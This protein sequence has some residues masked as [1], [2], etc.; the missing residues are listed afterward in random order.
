M[1]ESSGTPTCP[2]C[3]SPSIQA[4]PVRRSSIARALLAE[5]VFDSTAAG[6]AASTRTIILNTCLKCGTQWL[7]G[8]QAEERLRVLSGQRGEQAKREL[9]AGEQQAAAAA[10]KDRNQ[11]AVVLLGLLG[12]IFLAIVAGTIYNNRQAEHYARIAKARADSVEG[13]WLNSA[14]LADSARAA[15]RRPKREPLQGTQ[16]SLERLQGIQDSFDADRA[17]RTLI[18]EGERRR[19]QM[20]RI[21]LATPT[22]FDTVHLSRG[23][24]LTRDVIKG[25]YNGL[26]EPIQSYKVTYRVEDTDRNWTMNFP[27]D[28]ITLG[29]G[30]YRVRVQV[31]NTDGDHEVIVALTGDD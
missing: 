26:Q 23:Y 4:V 12:F 18:A 6:V 10:A 2:N 20:I 27:A 9:I 11:N 19:R 14:P 5:I 15:R 17:R 25:V 29:R 24:F 31:G 28:S 13:A 8:T 22:Q 1:V 7:P 16:D 30:V 3:N 21:D